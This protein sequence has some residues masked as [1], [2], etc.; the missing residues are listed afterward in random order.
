M[1][2]MDSAFEQM[3]VLCVGLNPLR[4]GNQTRIPLKI[5][6]KQ[7]HLRAQKL[8]VLEKTLIPVSQFQ[9]QRVRVRVKP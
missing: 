4:S 9:R 1:C 8:C 5:C 2:S 6:M 7:W 3:A